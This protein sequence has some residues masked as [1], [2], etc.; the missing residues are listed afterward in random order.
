MIKKIISTYANNLY[1]DVMFRA[2]QHA[3]LI[4]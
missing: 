3:R 1:Q 2:Y 4:L